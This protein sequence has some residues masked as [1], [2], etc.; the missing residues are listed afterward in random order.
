MATEKEVWSTAIS[1]VTS[2]FERSGI[3]E[4]KSNA[5]YLAMYILG[6]WDKARLRS[7][8]DQEISKADRARYEEIVERRLKHE[9]LQHIIGETEFFGLRLFTSSA[10]LIPRPDTEIVVEES[11][12]EASQFDRRDLKILDVGTGSGAIALALASRLPGASVTGIDISSDAIALAEKNL[13]RLNLS[14]V[15]FEVG[16]IFD[17]DYINT[18]SSSIDMLISNPP[19]IS[20]QEFQT[21]DTEVRS[22]DPRIALT[23]ESDGLS[24]YRRIAEDARKVLKEDGKIIVEIGFG[25]AATVEKIFTA[26]GWSQRRVVKDLQGI[27]RVMVIGT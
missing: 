1:N 6:V 3:S 19:Y 20:T 13:K 27:E 12:K 4:A 2:I 8:L 23:D 14:N 7:F 26:A 21:L 5:E 18:F 10:A 15:S 25:S 9:P 17:D 24:F 11:L 16:D 22:F